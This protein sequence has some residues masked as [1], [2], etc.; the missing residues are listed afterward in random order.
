LIPSIID[1]V[2][3]SKIPN[4]ETLK[5]N[6]MTSTG[7]DLAEKVYDRLKSSN[8]KWE[9][10]DDSNK[11][12]KIEDLIRGSEEIKNGI[13]TE[14]SK[15]LKNIFKYFVKIDQGP[16]TVSLSENKLDVFA[17]LSNTVFKVK[18]ICT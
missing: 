8:I 5:K 17:P 4:I 15:G 16:V 18:R 11:F 7:V 9:T 14:S 12:Q 13:K 3:F 6:Y 1:G 2:E 10:M